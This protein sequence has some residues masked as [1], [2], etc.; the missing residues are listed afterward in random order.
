M[1]VTF[2]AGLRWDE[3]FVLRKV[4][5]TLVCSMRVDVLSFSSLLAASQQ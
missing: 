1:A 5:R 4:W 2:V 3:L